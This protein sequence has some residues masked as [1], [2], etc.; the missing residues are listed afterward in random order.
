MSTNNANNPDGGQDTQIHP[1]AGVVGLHGMEA[2]PSLRELAGPDSILLHIPQEVFYEVCQT[3]KP[4]DVLNL[5]RTCKTLNKFLMSRVSGGV[6]WRVAR[7]NIPNLP[8][9]PPDMSEAQ[10]AQALFTFECQVC[11][12]A[13][14]EYMTYWL[15][16]R[17]CD[18]C[19]QQQLA[20]ISHFNA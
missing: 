6:V 20:L 13:P 11:N 15:R 9:C 3:L 18:D 14:V 2:V 5:A 4:V 16:T 10:Y 1:L 8:E 19:V 12:V 17:L 7:Q